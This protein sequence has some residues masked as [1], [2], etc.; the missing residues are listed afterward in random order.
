MADLK[1][2][3]V[4]FSF[5]HGFPFAASDRMNIPADLVPAWPGSLNLQLETINPENFRGQPFCDSGELTL[6]RFSV[7][8]S[9]TVKNTA[10]KQE[11]AVAAFFRDRVVGHPAPLATSQSCNNIIFWPL[12]VSTVSTKP[13]H[14]FLGSPV[15]LRHRLCQ[16]QRR[17]TL[18]VLRIHISTV[19]Q[20]RLHN[21]LRTILGSVMQWCTT[22]IVLCVDISTMSQ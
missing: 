19:G 6:F 1:I 18:I 20:Q 3:I 4:P 10:S 21:I 16:K 22:L 14:L 12:V 13:F 5:R 11:L 2:S 8:L 7:K 9:G 15:N 17:L